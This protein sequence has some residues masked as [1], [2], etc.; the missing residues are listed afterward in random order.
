MCLWSESNQLPAAWEGEFVTVI[1]FDP[2]SIGLSVLQ[3]G[4]WLR[5]I[6]GKTFETAIGWKLII[7][8]YFVNLE[9]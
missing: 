4:N 2:N 6:K 3:E 5:K 7:L 1:L 9:N 8:S